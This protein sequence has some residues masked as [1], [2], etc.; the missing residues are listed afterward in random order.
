[1]MRED[2][3]GIIQFLKAYPRMSIAPSYGLALVL[4]G[5]FIFS[6]CPRNDVKICD[7]YH[8]KIKVPRAFPKDIPRVIEL[9][10]KI[11]RNG[12]F[13]VNYEYDNTLCLGSPLRLLEKISIKPN[14]VGF[15]ENCLVPYLYAITYKLQFGGGFIFSELAHGSQGI[16]EDYLSL[17][18]LTDPKQVYQAIRLLGMEQK[19]ANKQ[20]CPC[21]CGLNLGQCNF[22]HKLNKYRGLA[23]IAWFRAHLADCDN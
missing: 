2:E 10:G 9:D 11:P 5:T 16:M 22:H 18:G 1:M 4:R 23:D 7:A 21:G 3:T 19:L 6:A 14:L 17:F 15:A 20:P 13:H 12:N 8:L